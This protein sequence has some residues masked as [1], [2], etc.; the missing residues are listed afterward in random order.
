[1]SQ[2]RTLMPISLKNPTISCKASLFLASTI[3]LVP[4]DVNTFIF[5]MY[6]VRLLVVCMYILVSVF[7]PQVRNW[8][9]WKLTTSWNTLTWPRIWKAMWNTKVCYGRYSMVQHISDNSLTYMISKLQEVSSNNCRGTFS[10]SWLS[11]IHVNTRVRS[12]D[13]KVSTIH[14]QMKAF[15]AV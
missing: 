7:V 1:M 12:N 6:L 8:P 13:R 15:R 9:T 14:T 11:T 5:Y 10:Y 2:Y 3:L 4:V